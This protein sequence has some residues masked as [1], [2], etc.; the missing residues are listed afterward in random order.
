VNLAEAQRQYQIALEHARSAR[1]QA[2]TVVSFE[3][4]ADEARSEL[5]DAKRQLDVAYLNR[6]AG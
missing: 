2:A 6:I 4:E 1:E 5:I 3:D